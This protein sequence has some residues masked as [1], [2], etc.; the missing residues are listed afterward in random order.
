[1]FRKHG[2]ISDDTL[3]WN[4]SEKKIV[5]LEGKIYFG[6]RQLSLNVMKILRITRGKKRK[7]LAKTE[8]YSYNL[9][10]E[11]RKS[12]QV[13]RYDNYD[14]K[15]RKG[16]K[17]VHHCHRFDPP[18]REILNS[19]FELHPEDYPTLGDVIREAYEYCM[20]HATR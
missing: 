11:R 19:P 3:K 9:N 1:H 16:H 7:R 6:D 15:P 17:S 2:I 18:G 13:F 20:A 12:S 14:S 8:T 5:T 10:Y 4:F